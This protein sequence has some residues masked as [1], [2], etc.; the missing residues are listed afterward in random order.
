MDAVRKSLG[1]LEIGD[2]ASH[3]SLAAWPLLGDP[4]DGFEYLLLDRAVRSGLARVT[5]VSESGRVPD[6]KLTNDADLPVLVLEGEELRGGKQNRTTNLTI[7]APP[8]SVV[9]VPVSCV[10]AGRWHAASGEAEVADHVHMARGRAAKAASVSCSIRHGGHARADQR[11]VWDDIAEV[12]EELCAASPTRAMG[13]IFESQRPR[14]E[15]FVAAFA[16]VDRQVGVL[17]AIA[18]EPAGFDVFSQHSTLVEMLPKLV[19]SYAVDAIRAGNG[20]G[21]Q[22]EADGARAMVNSVALAEVETFAA[23]GLGTTVRISADG[24][25]G[26]GLVHNGRLIHLAAFTVEDQ[27]TASGGNGRGMASLSA[28]RRGYHH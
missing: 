14:L 4:G 7:L 26:G 28:R 15:E 12:A 21:R 3:G 5:E 23:I 18:G 11:R 8:R 9:I 20:S 13:A 25:V 10:E 17:F 1:N 22:F 24:L 16:P 27:R 19:R 6:L 2:V